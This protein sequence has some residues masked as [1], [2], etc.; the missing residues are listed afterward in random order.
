[1]SVILNAAL[2]GAFIASIAGLFPWAALAAYVAIVVKRQFSDEV[3]VRNI[4]ELIKG[5][6]RVLQKLL[7][8]PIMF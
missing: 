2:V 5:M 8:C 4:S 1:M 7:K 3:K 6:S